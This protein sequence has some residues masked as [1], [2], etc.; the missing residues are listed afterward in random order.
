[1]GPFWQDV[2]GSGLSRR[3]KFFVGS[4]ET[5]E[6]EASEA[7]MSFQVCE[8]HLDFL[9]S[10][11]FVIGG[12]TAQI[13]DELARLFVHVA[14]DG[15]KWR[16]RASLLDRTSAVSVFP[17]K[18]TLD[19]VCLLDPAQRH[20]VAFKAGVAV[21]FRVILEMAEI[22]FALGLMLAI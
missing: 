20:L 2:L 8:Q 15:S 16:V 3:G 17:G 1:M 11:A 7:E 6:A 9:S 10:L 12:G 19:P 13:A 14:R 21:A 18:V 4:F 5:L 22:V